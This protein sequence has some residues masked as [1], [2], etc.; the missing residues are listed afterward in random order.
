MFRGLGMALVQNVL[1]VMLV[2]LNLCHISVSVPARQP[3]NAVALLQPPTSVATNF[4]Y[5][6]QIPS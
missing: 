6:I 1:N 4:S 2:L 5:V 3:S